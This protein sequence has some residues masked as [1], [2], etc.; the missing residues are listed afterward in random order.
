[1]P[2]N[3]IYFKTSV[4][5]GIFWQIYW[6]ESLAIRDIQLNLKR[7]IVH[8]FSLKIN[9]LVVGLK[10]LIA[11][12]NRLAVIL[13]LTLKNSSV[14]RVPP[15]VVD[16]STEAEEYSLLETVTKKRLADHVL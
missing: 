2:E 3:C 1:M 9:I 10:G 14:G 7:K 12:M 4:R 6:Y 15:F 13:T 8:V 5:S 11:K 16:L